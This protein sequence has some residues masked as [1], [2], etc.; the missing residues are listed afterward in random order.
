[1][2][3]APNN[4]LHR[5]RWAELRAQHQARQPPKPVDRVVWHEKVRSEHFF[6]G[7]HVGYSL[8]PITLARIR[9]LESKE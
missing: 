8:A 1:M 4:P 5:A 7:K 6:D 9:F 2:R 3:G